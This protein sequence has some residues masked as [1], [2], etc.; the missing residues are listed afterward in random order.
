MSKDTDIDSFREL[1]GEDIH[2]LRDEHVAG[3]RQPRQDV[4]FDARRRAASGENLAGSATDPNM[5][6]LGE[7]PRLEP[8]DEMAWKKDGVQE[9][10]YRKLRL[11]RYPIEASL[12][13]H[14]ATVREAREAVFNFVRDAERHGWRVVLIMH[15]KG[16]QSATPARL[17]SYTQAWLRQLPAVLAFHSAQ[18]HH[19]G[20]GATYVLLR[21]NERQKSD[22]RE[23]HGRKGYM[24][25]TL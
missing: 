7:V 4:D 2:E 6:T 21:K 18:R 24:P 20:Y 13:L 17:K 23:Q 9:G 5:L 11:G 3:P 15:G 16:E 8:W 14:R 1:V 25:H 12:D 10:V 19:G 22:T